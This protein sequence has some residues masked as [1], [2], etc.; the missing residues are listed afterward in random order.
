MHFFVNY[1]DK[2]LPGYVLPI[3]LACQAWRAKLEGVDTQRLV[4]GAG[5]EPATPS[6]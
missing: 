2:S 3:V 6:L 1:A 4:G 5:F